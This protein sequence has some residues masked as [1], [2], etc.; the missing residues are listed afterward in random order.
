MKKYYSLPVTL[1]VISLV[2]FVISCHKEKDSG[3]TV[4][5]MDQLNVPAN[6]NWETS[7]EVS[8]SVAVDMPSMIGTLSRI[9][10]Y[11]GDPYGS[12]KILITGSAG[13]NYPFVTGLRIPTALKQ[14]YLELTKGDG[15][16]RITP[17][18]ISDNIAYTFTGIKLF[19]ENYNPATDPDCTTGCTQTISGSSPVSITGGKTYCVTG[20][21]NGTITS[22]T[23]GTLKVCGT[24]NL[25][26]IKIN[27]PNCNIIVTAG[28]TL[29]IDS[30]YMSSTTTL[31]VYQGGHAS[32][33]G[34]AMAIN[35]KVFNYSNDFSIATAFSFYGE[36]QNYGNFV[37]KN[38]ATLTGSGGKLT[39]SGYFNT[40]G[41]FKVLA[42]LIN[43]GTL[44]V[45]NYLHFDSPSVVTNNCLMFSHANMHIF[46]STITGNNGYFK[47]NQEFHVTNYAN[48]TLQNQSMISCADYY[49]DK[50]VLGQ[51]SKSSIKITG[52]GYI[53]GTNKVSGPIEL[54]TTSGSLATGNLSNFVNGGTLV[55]ISNATNYIPISSCNP[56]GIGSP[57]PPDSDGDGVPNNLDEFPNDASRAYTNYYPAKGQ[58]G[59]LAF[60]DLWPGKGDYDMNDLVVDYTFKIISNA[61]NKIVDIIPSFYVR[62]V[63]ASLQNGFGFQFDKLSP[64]V[65]SSVSGYSIQGSYISLASNGVENAQGNAVIIVFDN[66]NNVIHRTGG[67]YFNT[68]KNVPYGQSDNIEMTIHF[69][70]PQDASAVG[71]APYNPFLI[72][73]LQRG[74]EIHLP[75][76]IPTS[77]ADQALFGTGEDNSLPSAGRYYKSSK[78]LPWAINITQKFDYTW[79]QVQVISGYLKFG[80]WAESGGSSDPD[81]YSNLSGYRD[82]SQIYTKP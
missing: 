6:F 53:S 81:W 78:N 30:L 45:N 57:P 27:A 75:D 1:V 48:L 70:I 20:T 38:D 7:R 51:G 58:F 3:T 17:V 79:E 77:L 41:F 63:G 13:Y 59:S 40:Y 73:N 43:N 61:Q 12:G 72:K 64:A 35:S 26:F 52:N 33:R 47:T 32:I 15:S 68:E 62:A 69:A 60:E 50:D 55:K 39:N 4:K 19:P 5:T 14:I 23:S 82:V 34:F 54:A 80:N 67:N 9:R 42:V 21:F 8:L 36:I 76:R 2:F 25:G 10:V 31:T 74:V 44:E 18:N 71:T 16:S 65:I 46:S 11:D 66:A 22:W 24:A 49:Q 29:T 28:G 37:I 56:E